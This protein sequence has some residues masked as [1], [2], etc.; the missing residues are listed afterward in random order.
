MDDPSWERPTQ[1][2]GVLESDA[3]QAHGEAKTWA[4]QQLALACLWASES[5]PSPR[6]AKMQRR[7]AV[8][9]ARAAAR[10]ALAPRPA[11]MMGLVELWGLWRG[12]DR[13]VERVADRFVERHA[14]ER[15]LLGVSWVLRG[16]ME[17]ERERWEQAARAYR[18]VV[19]ELDHPLY[20]VALYRTAHCWREMGR[21]DDARSA[22][23]EVAARTGTSAPE[24]RL[25]LAAR[26]ELRR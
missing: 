10:G 4:N 5:A 24:R 8:Q 21:P 11:A 12:G 9:A 15:T 14:A 17:L 13:A 25:A 6:V 22:L 20:A 1:E 23:R 7:C 3:R 26:E 19:A 2:I 16:E 18:F